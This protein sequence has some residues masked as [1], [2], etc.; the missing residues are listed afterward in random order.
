MKVASFALVIVL[1]AGLLTACSNG[2]T[3]EPLEVRYLNFKVYDPVYVGIDKGLFDCDVKIVGDVLA[4]PTAIQAVAAGAADAALSSVPAIINANAG[5]LPIQGVVDIQTTTDNQYLQRW[6]VRADSDIQ[7]IEDLKGK[8]VAVNL[9]RSSF[10]YTLLRAFENHG[11]VEA[12]VELKLL[13][14][15]DQV[16]ALAAG[17]VDAIGLMVPYQT[18]LANKFPGLARELFNDHDEV[19]EGP[20]HVSL[21]FVNKLWAEANP[22]AARCFVAGI[23]K[24]IDWIKANPAEAQ[25][26]QAKYIGI[27]P[28]DVPAT[29]DYTEKGAVNVADVQWWLDYLIVRGDVT[30]KQAAYP[31]MSADQIATNAYNEAVK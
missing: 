2:P 30:E 11:M 20:K 25:T 1:L 7:T 16:N 8:I 5:G 4:G 29:Y 21:I 14:F 24:S 13:S 31:W 9:I 23:V 15:A 3:P 17:Q 22:E 19:F 28:V 6:Y 12:D 27:D 10:H 26:I 18:L